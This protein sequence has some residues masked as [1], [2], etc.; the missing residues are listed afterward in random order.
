[1]IRILEKSKQLDKAALVKQNSMRQLGYPPNTPANTPIGSTGTTGMIGSLES[2]SNNN[3]D[4]N[5]N[6]YDNTTGTTNAH[7]NPHHDATPFFND[8]IREGKRCGDFRVAEAAADNWLQDEKATLTSGAI[9]ACV[10][11]YSQVREL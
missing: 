2:S 8:L 9:T 7:R 10:S 4:N 5:N 1:M 6:N 11:I 3:N